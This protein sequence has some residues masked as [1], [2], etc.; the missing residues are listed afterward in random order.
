MG[1]ALRGAD[2]ELDGERQVVVNVPPG[3]PVL[4]RIADERSRRGLESALAQ[5]LGRP[6]ELRFRSGG[7]PTSDPAQRRTT[8][9]G[10]KQERLRRLAAEEPV[11]GAAVQEWD[12]ELME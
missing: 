9:E 5:R 4:D 7:G 3:S 10:A 2:L 11:L 6:V 8:A 12:L 1:V